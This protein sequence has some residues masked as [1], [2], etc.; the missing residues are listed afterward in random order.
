[1]TIASFLGVLGVL[2]FVLALLIVTLRLLKRYAP[3]ATG[4][5]Q[6]LTLEVVQRLP[7]GPRQSI[8]VVRIGEKFV[9][10][11]VGDGGVRRVAD[12]TAPAAARPVDGPAAA[13][14]AQ[15]PAFAMP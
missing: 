10:V 11:S 14:V 9:A 15:R 2:G 1:M 12:V 6:C 4:T 8:A 13:G 3:F 5:N 7:L